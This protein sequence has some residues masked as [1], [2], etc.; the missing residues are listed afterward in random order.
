M[1]SL[2]RKV[3]NHEIA[4]LYLRFYPVSYPNLPPLPPSSSSSDH[5]LPVLPLCRPS[6]NSIIR[7]EWEKIAGEIKKRDYAFLTIAINRERAGGDLD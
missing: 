4:Q 3:S 5:V 7:F 6:R 2:S 1:Q